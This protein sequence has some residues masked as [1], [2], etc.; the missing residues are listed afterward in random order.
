[1][2][3]FL[4]ETSVDDDGFYRSLFEN[5]AAGIGRTTWD[6]GR[7][8]LANTRLAEIFGYDNKDEFIRD[9]VFSEHCLEKDG[10]ERLLKQ[11]RTNP[12]SLVETSFTK[13]DGSL[14]Y[15]EAEVRVDKKQGFIDFVIIDVSDRVL[16]SEA[17]IESE[18]NYQ[19]L[20]ENA[21]VGIGRSWL[22]GGSPIMVNQ[23]LAEMFGFESPET[24]I[25]E[26]DFESHSID[27][28]LRQRMIE[29][30]KDNPLQVSEKIFSKRD[31]SMITVLG[32]DRWVPGDEWYDYVVVDISE[33]A[34]TRDE[35]KQH[36]EHLEARIESGTADLRASEQIF[37]S[38]YEL[39]PDISLITDLHSGVCNSVNE[40]FLNTTGFERDEVIGVSTTELNLW[41]DPADRDRLVA[42]LEQ[43]GMVS[44]LT[45]DFRK[46]D[47][48]TWPGILAACIIQFQGRPHILSTTKDISDLRR[49][50]EIAVNANLAKSQFLSS[51]SHE[52]RTPLNAILGY[53]QMLQLNKKRGLSVKQ[54]KFVDSIYRS[55][56]H[57][58]HLINQVLELSRIETGNLELEI[59]PVE[60]L[61]LLEECI[62]MVMTE[63]GSRSISIKNL[64][65]GKVLPRIEVDPV[66]TREILLNLLSNAINYNHEGGRVVLEARVLGDDQ[67]RMSVID[68]GMGI[69]AGDHHRVFEPFDR[70]GNLSSTFQG[71]GIG[72]ALSKRLVEDMNGSIGFQSKF[73]K[74][75]EFWIDVPISKD[76]I[77]MGQIERAGCNDAGLNRIL[78][79]NPELYRILYVE[80]NQVNQELMDS[81]FEDVENAILVFA[82]DAE[83]G[84]EMAKSGTPDLVM[85]DIGLPDMDG[86]EAAKILKNLPQTRD[87]PVIAI[88]AA[89]MDI[90]IDRAADAG[91]VS[92][93]TKPFKIVELLEMIRDALPDLVT[94]V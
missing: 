70:L 61:M 34:R 10:H 87:I 72:L 71:V 11:Y 15:V 86:I 56:E 69:A 78:M 38:F 46:K 94:K 92:Y 49:V 18:K 29:G 31:G 1:M 37:R 17:L 42:G 58:L 75:S 64:A 81:I 53:S 50:Q 14:V 60:P 21:A 76:S 23:R 39:I 90:D 67:L 27:K 79:A 9:F 19:A 40:G 91:F 62:D 83:S 85:M 59:A 55:G 66:R 5:S 7:V 74:G 43:D 57:L 24:M 36:K 88:S 54:K 48:S 45:A 12:G 13:K 6:E 32:Y 65:A 89:V 35:L 77:Q 25:A 80:D 51:M 73:G 26:Y 4:P 63:S 8:V 47:G 2:N 33:L 44:N 20:F 93:A 52:L 68:S 16:T 84:I 3:E 22:K 82:N 28:T 41:C 30:F